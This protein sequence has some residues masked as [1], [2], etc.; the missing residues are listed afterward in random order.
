MDILE[1]NV[2]GPLHRPESRA[3]KFG[4]S[5]GEFL[6]NPSSYVV[7]GSLPFK[8]GT[9]AL[10][11]L[12]SEAGGQLGEGTSLEGPLR[13]LGGVLGGLGAARVASASKV[14]PPTAPVEDVPGAG[15]R[16]LYHYTD[17]AGLNGI[18]NEG[19][20]NPSLKARRPRDVKFGNGQYLTD[21][22]PGTMEP[23]ELSKALVLNTHQAKKFTHYLEI[24]PDGL[25]VIKGRSGVY[26]I[27]NEGP[28][29]LN[30]RIISSGKVSDQ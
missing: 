17:E 16:N 26:V 30:N 21:I 20:L 18:L 10:A 7:P 23:E 4:A 24:N 28:L 22:P 15:L 5:A 2:T 27:P 3:G 11:G 6:G 19:K 29:D 12:G 25:N 1:K 9:A 8:V 13:F 14:K